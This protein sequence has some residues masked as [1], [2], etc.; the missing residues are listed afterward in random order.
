MVVEST[1][2]TYNGCVITL[3][4]GR[5]K[6][7]EIFRSVVELEQAGGLNAAGNVYVN[8]SK[9]KTGKLILF[10]SCGLFYYAQTHDWTNGGIEKWFS[11][12]TL[13]R[14]SFTLFEDDIDLIE[15]HGDQFLPYLQSAFLL[16]NG[17]HYVADI[18]MTHCDPTLK[19]RFPV[20]QEG[21]TED[22]YKSRLLLDSSAIACIVGFK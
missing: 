7:A 16:E 19:T 20:R 11:D 14:D 22:K 17:F 8:I 2:R 13:V 1:T 15:E 21:E 9:Q 12:G 5:D 10:S 6:E 18:D 4:G 3:W